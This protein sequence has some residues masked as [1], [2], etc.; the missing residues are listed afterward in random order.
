MA[1]LLLC[2][3]LAAMVWYGFVQSAVMLVVL[4]VGV[5]LAGYVALRFVGQRYGA[6][7]LV[8]L[9]AWSPRSPRCDSRP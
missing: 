2:Y 7:L 8:S 5:S 1:F 4:I 9:A 6:P 3:M